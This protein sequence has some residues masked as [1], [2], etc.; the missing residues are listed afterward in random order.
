MNQVGCCECLLDREYTEFLLALKL[1]LK[2][3][4]SDFS[5]QSDDRQMQGSC[6]V[7][8]CFLVFDEISA[9]ISKPNNNK[10]YQEHVCSCQNLSER[11]EYLE[12]NPLRSR[13]KFI[14]ADRSHIPICKTS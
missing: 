7:L 11:E 9:K 1:D 2:I 5:S 12:D 4:G 6:L 3:W 13:C 14:K 10:K 8:K